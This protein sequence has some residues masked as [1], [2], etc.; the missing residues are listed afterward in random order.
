MFLCLFCNCENRETITQIRIKYPH[1]VSEYICTIS[2]SMVSV[3]PANICLSIN[4]LALPQTEGFKLCSN[5]LGCSK[6]CNS[7]TVTECS[8]YMSN[9]NTTLILHK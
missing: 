3:E 6:L 2:R 9:Q 5:N 1:G 8:R 4:C 7:T